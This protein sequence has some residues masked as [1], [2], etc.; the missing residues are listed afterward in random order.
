MSLLFDTLHTW[1]CLIFFSI[2]STAF[3]FCPRN[4]TATRQKYTLCGIQVKFKAANQF[5]F[6]GSRQS[7][8]NLHA[9]AKKNKT[10]NKLEPRLN[11]RLKSFK[12]TA[13]AAA[14]PYH[15]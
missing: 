13:A 4:T 2:Q 9:Q 11:Q 15:Q 10:L 6:W 5:V 7:R 14:P 12:A 3:K 1:D 8:G